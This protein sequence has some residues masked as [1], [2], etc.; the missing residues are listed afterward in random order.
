MDNM[1]LLRHKL[2]GK[3]GLYPEH[4]AG[5]D[6]FEVVDDLYEP[7]FDCVVHLE[8]DDYSEGELENGE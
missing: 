7:C 4:F 5:Y 2:T 6:Y 3:T 8:D 1:I